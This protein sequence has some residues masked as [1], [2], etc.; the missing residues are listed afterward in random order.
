MMDAS[1]ALAAW[2]VR[3]LRWRKKLR[4]CSHKLFESVNQRV[5]VIA[6]AIGTSYPLTKS[7]RQKECSQSSLQGLGF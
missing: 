5:A 7:P 6:L 3:A 4:E 1:G 2:V